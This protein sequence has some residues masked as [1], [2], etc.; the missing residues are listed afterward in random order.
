MCFLC[1]PFDVLYYL[2]KVI[3]RIGACFYEC[4][5]CMMCVDLYSHV[6]DPGCSKYIVVTAVSPVSIS[7]DILQYFTIHCIKK[8]LLMLMFEPHAGLGYDNNYYN[9]YIHLTVFIPGQP[10]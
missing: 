8:L 2:K 9:Y 6:P 5:Y 7:D 10:G 4:I 1:H 3:S